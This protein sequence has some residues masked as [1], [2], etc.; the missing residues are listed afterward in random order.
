[1]KCISV[2][3]GKCKGERN[4]V[5]TAP[6]RFKHDLIVQTKTKFW[7]AREIALHLDGTQDFRSDNVPIRVDLWEKVSGNLCEG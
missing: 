4:A 1:M 6:S 3:M 7:H 2:G 5:R